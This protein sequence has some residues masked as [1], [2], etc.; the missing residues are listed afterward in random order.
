MNLIQGID[1]LLKA[2]YPNVHAHFKEINFNMFNYIWPVIQVMFTDILCKNDWL[3]FMDFLV[4]HR[5]KPQLLLCFVASYLG[6]F[7][8][9][10]KSI[11]TAD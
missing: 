4:A 11:R 6:Y 3:A 2:H 1:D 5:E 10:L 8:S 7:E 9:G